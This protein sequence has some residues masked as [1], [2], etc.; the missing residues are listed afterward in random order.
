LN[1]PVPARGGLEAA[2]SDDGDPCVSAWPRAR[3]VL[4][5]ADAAAAQGRKRAVTQHVLML[6]AA[7]LPVPPTLADICEHTVRTLDARALHRMRAVAT[8]W[9]HLLRRS[10]TQAWSADDGG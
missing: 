7:D 1:A 9:A 10:R 4:A 6:Q 5:K 8:T 2:H 3:R